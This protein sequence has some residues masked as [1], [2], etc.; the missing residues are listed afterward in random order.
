MFFEKGRSSLPERWNSTRTLWVS[1]RGVDRA[2]GL[3]QAVLSNV[4]NACLAACC[5][6]LHMQTMGNMFTQA[7]LTV[8]FNLQAWGA[9]LAAH[10]PFEYAMNN[11]PSECGGLC[12]GGVTDSGTKRPRT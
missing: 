12:A 9:N 6:L 8:Y 11:G 4:T 1:V 3:Q 10:F 2:S 7:C 5:L